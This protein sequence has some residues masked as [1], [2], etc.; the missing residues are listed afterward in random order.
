MINVLAGSI[1][2]ILIYRLARE[3]FNKKV[4]RLSALFIALHPVMAY[5]STQALTETLFSAVALG[6]VLVG[7]KGLN[8][9]KLGLG[10]AA[11]L[12]FGCGYLLRPEGVGFLIVFAGFAVVRML[13]RSTKWKWG[14]KI[15]L[16]A[17]AGFLIISAPYILYLKSATGNWTLSTKGTVN[18]QMESAVYFNDGEIKDPFFHL[19]NNNQQLP[20]DMAL[21]FGNVRELIQSDEGQKR[22]VKISLV[23]YAKKYIR[24]IHTLIKETIPQTVTVLF[25]VLATLGFFGEAYDSRQKWLCVYLSGFLFFFWSVLV[26]MFHVNPR[27]LYPLLPLLFVWVGNGSLYLAQWIQSNVKKTDKNKRGLLI[28]KS[29]AFI[30]LVM[31]MLFGILPGLF[32]LVFTERDSPDLWAEPVELKKA[33]LWLKENTDHPPVLM[34]PNKSVDYYA[35]Q[36]D[37][38][39]GAS[40]SYDSV[41]RNL[42]YARNRKVEYLVLSG[43]YLE[44]FPN[45]RPFFQ[46][47]FSADGLKLVYRDQLPCGIQTKVY[48]LE[49]SR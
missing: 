34:S 30:V 23:K 1:L 13:F 43:R 9:H 44:W 20:Y 38:K 40:F 8:N 32:K 6:G 39:K 25:L 37:M 14:S 33:G 21:H 16:S 31:V 11:G 42:A 47:D 3:L 12:L 18:Q 17:F 24:N 49:S 36:F 10:L 15:V 19:T 41:K 35:G 29:G 28:S 5:H 26:P 22:I 2:V 4:A 27:Y 7:W 48:Q 45:L 46:P